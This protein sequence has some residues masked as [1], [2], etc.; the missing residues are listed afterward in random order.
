MGGDGLKT[1]KNSKANGYGYS[2]EG[3]QGRALKKG[4]KGKKGKGKKAKGSSPPAPTPPASKITYT[5]AV[6]ETSALNNFFD[7]AQ[8]VS[9]LKAARSQNAQIVVFPEQAPNFEKY[10]PAT[11]PRL[12]DVPAP[13]DIDISEPCGDISLMWNDFNRYPFYNGNFAVIPSI[14]CVASLAKQYGMYITLN[15]IDKKPC[16]T[17]PVDV[18]HYMQGENA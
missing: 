12:V 18:A 10:P 2:N 7:Y 5:A 11:L 4:K 9:H 14:G 15:V 3:G 16:I 6:V 17:D 8:M 1:A 13:S